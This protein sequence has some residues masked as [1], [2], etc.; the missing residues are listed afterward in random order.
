MRVLDLFS[1]I[2]GFSLGLTRAGFRTVAFCEIEAYPRTILRKHWPDVPIFEDVRE[3]TVDSDGNLIYI[4]PNGDCLIQQGGA[5]M[6]KG[7]DNKYDNAQDLYKKGLS[8]GDCAEFYGITRQAMYKILS[9]RG[10][11]F[12]PQH[13]YGA[14]NHFFRGGRS[15]RQRSAGHTLEKAI[16]KGVIE[17]K[18]RC[19]NCNA[20]KTFSDGR[21][22]IQA[23]H[24]DYAKPL[25]VRWLCQ[26]CHHEWHKENR[27]KGGGKESVQQGSSIDVIC[28]GFP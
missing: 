26:Q 8:V 23:H 2:G 3:L 15:D 7:R 10:T 20:V 6:G 4:A 28:G 9:R 19:E 11:V 17:P 12:R 13:K 22:G 25:D 14:D 27:P 18:F 16:K 1:G 5:D 24:D 21:S